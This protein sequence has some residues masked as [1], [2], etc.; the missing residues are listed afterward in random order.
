M[1]KVFSYVVAEIRFKSGTAVTDISHSKIFNPVIHKGGSLSPLETGQNLHREALISQRIVSLTFSARCHWWCPE[2]ANIS[3]DRRFFIPRKDEKN[4][5]VIPQIKH[6]DCNSSG[7]WGNNSTFLRFNTVSGSKHSIRNCMWCYIDTC[8]LHKVD[9][10]RSIF[11]ETICSRPVLKWRAV[12]SIGPLPSTR[13]AILIY[14]STLQT[15]FIIIV[16][17]IIIISNGE[18]K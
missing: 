10:H 14:Q 13:S 8:I 16:I 1:D 12:I 5:G 6:N 18:E 15:I 2:Y 9:P 4:C 17:I 11:Q 3:W 7:C